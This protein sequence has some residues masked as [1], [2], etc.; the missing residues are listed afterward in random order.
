MS[1]FPTRE[2]HGTDKQ[3]LSSPRHAD[4]RLSVVDK[5]KQH[6][7]SLIKDKLSRQDIRPGNLQTGNDIKVAI[8]N[9][10]SVRNSS[11]SVKQ[12][13]R[14][15][16]SRRNSE[17]VVNCVDCNNN[18]ERF[19]M[20][21]E[22]NSDTEVINSNASCSSIDSGMSSY[23]GSQA[24]NDMALQSPDLRLAP[25]LECLPRTVTSCLLILFQ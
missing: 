25:T 15:T 3:K 12:Q 19:V 16:S 22:Y 20:C 8:N 2:C 10:L 14:S 21:E 9:S 13:D 4:Q 11:Q 23:M 6:Q 18:N 17:P 24:T 5:C 7:H 1:F